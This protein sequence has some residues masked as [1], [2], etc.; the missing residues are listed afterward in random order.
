MKYT[1]ICDHPRSNYMV[2]NPRYMTSRVMS[3][4]V[5]IRYTTC[6]ICDSMRHVVLCRGIT[7]MLQD[8]KMKYKELKYTVYDVP[9]MR[10][11]TTCRCFS[12][13]NGRVAGVYNP[14]NTVQSKK[15]LPQNHGNKSKHRHGLASQNIRNK[16]QNHKQ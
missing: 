4:T 11:Y 16:H 3:Y 2:V 15:C 13:R 12:Q 10:L 9:Y 6:R 1:T 14:D 5:N 8:S 7:V